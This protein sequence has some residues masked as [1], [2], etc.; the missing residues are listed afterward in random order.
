MPVA[1]TRVVAASETVVRAKD[2]SQGWSLLVLQQFGTERTGS[3]SVT[4]WHWPER[5]IQDGTSENPRTPLPSNSFELRRLI[6]ASYRKTLQ[7][8]PKFRIKKQLIKEGNSRQIAIDPFVII[9]T[10]GNFPR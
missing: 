2:C 7:L 6:A 1:V 3:A 9:K 5:I 8:D 4:C 10:D